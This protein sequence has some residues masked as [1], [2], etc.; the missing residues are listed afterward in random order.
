MLS[1]KNVKNGGVA[2]IFGKEFAEEARMLFPAISAKVFG[3]DTM[4]LALPEKKEP[5]LLEIKQKVEKREAPQLK[6][7]LTTTP[8]IDKPDFA[9]YVKQ[10]VND[11][12][13]QMLAFKLIY[14][15]IYARKNIDITKEL[16][17]LKA[18]R[19]LKPRGLKGPTIWKSGVIRMLGL[20]DLALEI[21][22]D[23]V[24]RV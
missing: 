20:N 14:A 22:R 13:K 3:L 17:K 11:E 21:A 10:C 4:Q 12:S 6:L 19:S 18:E 2:I 16:A 9:V 24:K 15:E 5:S 1:L 8:H 23:V 7:S